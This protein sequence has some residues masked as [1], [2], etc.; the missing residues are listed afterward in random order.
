M[1][2]YRNSKWVCDKTAGQWGCWAVFVLLA[3]LGVYCDEYRKERQD[4]HDELII[5]H[6]KRPLSHLYAAAKGSPPAAP[7]CLHG[8]IIPNRLA[9]RK[10]C[11]LSKNLS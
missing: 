8:V 1:G 6:T 10:V 3:V 7:A 4:D 5:R 11:F 2:P 9:S